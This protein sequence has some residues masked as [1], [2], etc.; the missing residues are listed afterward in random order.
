MSPIVDFFYNL[1]TTFMQAMAPSMFSRLKGRWSTPAVKAPEQT[2]E[3]QAQDRE[4]LE[5]AI[6][7]AVC[8]PFP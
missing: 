3:E 7:N 2:V 8:Y 6:T 5:E 1:P 4:V